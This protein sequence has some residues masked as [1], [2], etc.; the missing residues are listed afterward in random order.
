[1]SW[2]VKYSDGSKIGSGDS[3]RAAAIEALEEGLADAGIV[4]ET[5]TDE[6]LEVML[7]TVDFSAEQEREREYSVV[8]EAGDGINGQ[9]FGS[10][11][12]AKAAVERKYS[13]GEWDEVAGTDFG[14]GSAAVENSYEYVLSATESAARIDNVPCA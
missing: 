12:E 2:I 14:F 11:D 6:M 13:G 1:M 4:P 5:L 9:S 10:L 3:F 7:D 8:S